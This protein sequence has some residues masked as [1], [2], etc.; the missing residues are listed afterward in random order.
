MRHFCSEDAAK[1]QSVSLSE[2]KTT[3]LVA[4]LQQNFVSV[5]QSKALHRHRV[6][7]ILHLHMI[8]TGKIKFK[9]PTLIKNQYK[10]TCLF[11]SKLLQ[12][13]RCSISPLFSC[14]GILIIQ[15]DPDPSRKLNN[16]QQPVL[17][18]QLSPKEN[19]QKYFTAAVK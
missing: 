18:L 12:T 1:T 3:N 19:V 16:P 10:W 14:K 13:N 17:F 15:V 6:C 9:R 8:D 5:A 4:C 11:L 2:G 7:K